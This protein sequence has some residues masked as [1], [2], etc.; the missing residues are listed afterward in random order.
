MNAQCNHSGPRPRHQGGLRLL[1]N[2]S[3]IAVLSLVGG[4]SLSA[5][6]MD[7]WNGLHREEL[8]A[9]FGTPT[10]E[11]ELPGG[12]R[13]A[14]YRTKISRRPSGSQ[15]YGS[16]RTCEMTFEMDKT[17]FIQGASQKGC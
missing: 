9:T 11:V 3:V 10:E 16:S 6:P 4:C 5:A 7:E 14:I 1:R 17:G 2:L 12:W 15:L 8:V 13:K